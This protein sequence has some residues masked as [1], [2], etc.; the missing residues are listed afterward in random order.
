MKS[1]LSL[2]YLPTLLATANA[3]PLSHEVA[4]AKTPAFFLAGDST[5]AV[6]AANGGGWG[7]GFLSF[8]ISPSFGQNKGHNGATTK[9][10]VDGGD[11]ATVKGLVSSNKANYDTYVTIQFGHNDQKETSGISIQQYQT[12]LQNLATDIKNLGGT[13]LLV[14]PLTRRSFPS[15]TPNSASD[16]LH[17]ERLATIAAA[18][19]TG[20]TYLDLNQASLNYIN[21][22]GATAAHVYDLNAGDSTHLNSWGSVVFGRIVADLLLEKKGDLKTW[23]RANETLSTLIKNGQPA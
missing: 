7:N 3:S 15:S 5:T 2:A 14:T 19:A 13:P 10:F 21:A 4:A 20:T 1:I 9:S 12:N 17:N 18:E 16:S 22:I 6:Q 8:L 11:W 23:I